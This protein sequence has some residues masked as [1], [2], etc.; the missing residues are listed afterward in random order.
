MVWPRIKDVL[1]RYPKRIV[2]VISLSTI[3]TFGIVLTSGT[4]PEQVGPVEADCV[5]TTEVITRD[6]SWTE[7][8]GSRTRSVVT[9]SSTT[10][11]T[12]P[13]Q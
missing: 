6:T 8:N 7:P 1:L 11:W 2:I 9:S 12:Y 5:V 3:L 4:S 13:T 10:T